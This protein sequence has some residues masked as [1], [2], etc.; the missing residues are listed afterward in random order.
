MLFRC[1]DIAKPFPIRWLEKRLPGGWGI[2][3][4][5]ILAGLIANLILRG[6]IILWP[7]G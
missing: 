6:I 1:L 5:D 2:V 7:G 3:A 4:D